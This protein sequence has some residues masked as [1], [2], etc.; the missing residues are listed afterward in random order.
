MDETDELAGRETPGLGTGFWRAMVAVALIK[1][2]L[3]AADH[4]PNFFM[5]DSGAFI[6][7]AL[8]KWFPPQRS[9][10]YGFLIRW[11]CLPVHS[12]D[13]LIIAQTL[14]GFCTCVVLGFCLRR[15]FS[16]S[17]G[18][19]AGMMI[20]SA[21]DPLQLLYERM[22][23]AEALSLAVLALVWAGSLSYCQRPR[24]VTLL[25]LQVLYVILISLRLQFLLPVGIL[26]LTLPLVGNL[27]VT[28]PIM[29][30]R[31]WIATVVVHAVVSVVAMVALHS[32]Y[33]VAEGIKNRQP[34]A[35]SYGTNGMALSAFAPLL[36]AKDAPSKPLAAAIRNDTAYP[37]ADR[38]LRNDQLWNPGG[39]IDRLN[40]AGGGLYRSDASESVIFRR[41]VLRDPVGIFLFGLR[42]YLDY[43]NIP[44]MPDILRPERETGPFDVEFT[45]AVEKNFYLDIRN[46]PRTG[47]SKTLHSWLPPWLVLLLASP[48]LLLGM[49]VC[50]GRGR[51]RETGLLLGIGTVMLAQ[52]TMLSTMTVYRYLQPLTFA[53]LLALGVIAQSACDHWIRTR[54]R[55]N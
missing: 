36:Q 9:W 26:L 52:N 35:Y 46:Y 3:L 31:P 13:P 17:Q 10:T 37:L 51:W 7:T 20:A 6:G 12:L 43:W 30:G 8:T 18:P 42:S 15:Y 11:T 22:V 32:A 24:L 50:A 47:I 41:M 40:K 23:M 33:R 21:L 16:V 54:S 53:T 2:G 1:A 38:A 28:R 48:L 5:G 29:G 14:A 25:V 44:S 4:T 45:A 19:A 34:P 27:G 55:G 39:L 49:M